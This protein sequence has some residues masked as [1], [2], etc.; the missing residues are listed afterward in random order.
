MCKFSGR[1]KRL[2]LSFSRKNHL[3]AS[4]LRALN[5]LFG[6]KK[7]SKNPITYPYLC[8][9]IV[10]VFADKF[11]IEHGHNFANNE[12][13]HLRVLKVAKLELLY[14]LDGDFDVGPIM[15]L[16]IQHHRLV[17]KNQ[18]HNYKSFSADVVVTL[19]RNLVLAKRMA[20]SKR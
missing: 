8:F 12:V 13:E 6:P 2:K 3:N 7:Q 15:T 10:E 9:G 11:Q 18:H 17:K 16:G 20:P 4:L 1:R 5:S 19:E 14:E